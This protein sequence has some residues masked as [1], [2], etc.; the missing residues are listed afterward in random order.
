MVWSIHGRQP[1][2]FWSCPFPV[3]LVW[4]TQQ[5]PKKEPP[6]GPWRV[7]AAW[8]SPGLSPGQF[9]CRRTLQPLCMRPSRVTQCSL[10]THPP[11]WHDRQPVGGGTPSGAKGLAPSG[12]CPGK[13]CLEPELRSHRSAIETCLHAQPSVTDIYIHILYIHILYRYGLRTWAAS[14]HP[15]TPWS[16]TR[17]YSEPRPQLQG[18]C[19]GCYSLQGLNSKIHHGFWGWKSMGYPLVMTNSNSHGKIHHF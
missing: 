11:A 15:W 4:G 18:T 1:A 10:S 12:H 17:R 14:K 13:A 7:N 8:P 9:P 19:C 3:G 6:Q 2:R 16:S 5:V